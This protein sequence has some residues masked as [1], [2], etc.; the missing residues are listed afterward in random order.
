MNCSPFGANRSLRRRPITGS[1]KITTLLKSQSVRNT[2]SASNLTSITPAEGHV[3]SPAYDPIREDLRIFL[4]LPKDPAMDKMEVDFNESLKRPLP[5]STDDD[6]EKSSTAKASKSAEGKKKSSG[7]S[8]SSRASPQNKTAPPAY[9]HTDNLA[10]VNKSSSLKKE[11]PTSYGTFTRAPYIVHFRL[12]TSKEHPKKRTAGIT[13]AKKLTSANIKFDNLQSYAFNTWKVTFPSK[14]AANAVFKNKYIKEV[15][16]IPYVP[17]Y[18]L[19][20]RFVI[21]G[22]PTDISLEEVKF[23]IEEENQSILI[24]D[25]FR[26]KRRDNSTRIWTDSESICIQKL[27]EDMPEH[28]SLYKTLCRATPYFASVRMCFNCGYF[29]HLAKYCEK[30][31]RCLQ[32]SSEDHQSS[33]E[34]SCQQPKKCINCGGDH[35]TV[36]HKCPRFIRNN[37]TAKI[38]AQDNLPFFEARTIALKMEKNTTAATAWSNPSLDVNLKN[39]PLLPQKKGVSLVNTPAIQQSIASKLQANLVNGG[40][41]PEIKNRIFELVERLLKAQDTDTLINRLEFAMKLHNDA[42]SEGAQ[43]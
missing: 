42:S 4:S 19:A 12:P 22:V 24:T 23:A 15:G 13:A 9:G 6:M 37:R 35:A 36:D 28:V 21:R 25:I 5:S 14:A 11:L 26:L 27:G 2:V 7:T 41:G 29:G 31:A 10:I 43:T 16:L 20:R 1:H 3:P 34:K 8:S 40:I 33:K 32:C 38:M 39:F 30:K 18:K 17:R